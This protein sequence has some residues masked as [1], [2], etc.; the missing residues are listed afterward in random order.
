MKHRTFGYQPVPC[1]V[2]SRRTTEPRL[3]LCL[4]CYLRH[5]RGGLRGSACDCCSAGDPRV[6]VRRTI[7]GDVHTLCANCA[8]V[9]G[10]RRLSLLA[11]REEIWPSWDRRQGDRRA[12]DRRSPVGRRSPGVTDYVTPSEERRAAP[13]GRRAGDGSLAAMIS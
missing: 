3:G 1:S 8:A 13:V 5:Y 2:C 11:L 9:L 10:R 4:A 6:L 7:F 12:R